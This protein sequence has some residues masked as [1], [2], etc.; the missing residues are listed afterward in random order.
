MSHSN[1]VKL[2]TFEDIEQAKV[3]SRQLSKYHNIDRVQMSID[4]PDGQRESIVLPGMVMQMLL[5]ILSDISQGN[6]ISVIPYQAELSTQ[7]AANLLNVSR[8]YLVKLLENDDIDHHKVGTHRRVYVKDL[9]EY[10]KNIDN[11]RAKSL[12]DLAQLSQEIGMEY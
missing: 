5:D 10:K 4:N 12:D 2:P 8:P 3:S 7:Q 1:I 6:A 11:A 9:L